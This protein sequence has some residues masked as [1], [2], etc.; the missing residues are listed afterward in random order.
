MNI[1]R[2]D[3][4]A[5]YDYQDICAKHP[6]LGKGCNTKKKFIDRKLEDGCWI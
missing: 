6:S 2:I 5:Y 3:N 4:L 1:V